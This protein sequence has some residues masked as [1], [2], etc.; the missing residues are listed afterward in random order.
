[1]KFVAGFLGSPPMNFIYGRIIRKDNFLY[2]EE[3]KFKVRI[4]KEM[5]NRL[6]PYLNKEVI[7]GIR[8][9]DIHDKLFVSEL[10]P[11]N[12]VKVIPEMIE[13]IGSEAYLYLTAGRH[14]LISRIEAHNRP[15]LNQEMEVVLDMGKAHFFDKDTEETIV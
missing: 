14:N 5:H 7:F 13:T 10:P 11:E 8:P 9:E 1:N 15:S 4:V 12:I 3:G 2:F 6:L